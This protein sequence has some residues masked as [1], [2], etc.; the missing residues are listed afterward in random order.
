MQTKI[1]P[2]YVRD[3]NFAKELYSYHYYKRPADIIVTIVC[4]LAIISGVI[5][6]IAMQQYLAIISIVL[7]IYIL[8]LRVIDAK[9]SVKILLDRDKESKHGSC[10]SLQN[11]VT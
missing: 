9:K 7:G 10:V 6:V 5:T 3:E 1:E 8:V 4:I 2:D 11:I